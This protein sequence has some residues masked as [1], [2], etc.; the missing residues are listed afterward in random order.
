MTRA[1]LD[2][3]QQVVAAHVRMNDERPHAGAG[4]IA[5]H[6]LD[7]GQ[8]LGIAGVAHVDAIAQVGERERAV[9]LARGLRASTAARFAT[10]SRV[11]AT[12]SP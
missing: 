10:V 7:R 2:L 12:T 5:Q 1:G 9:P 4:R 8:R 11:C 6:A 3:D